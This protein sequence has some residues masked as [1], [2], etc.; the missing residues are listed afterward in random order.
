MPYTDVAADPKLYDECKIHVTIIL[1]AIEKMRVD[2]FRDRSN[3][4]GRKWVDVVEVMGVKYVVTCRND[5]DQ[6]TI[7]GF[8]RAHIQRK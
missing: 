1:Q 3:K 7:I 6:D 4:K 2:R 5:G 8:R